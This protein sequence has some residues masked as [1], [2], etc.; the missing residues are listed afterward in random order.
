M[1]LYLHIQVY[2]INMSLSTKYNTS[3]TRVVWVVQ[4]YKYKI[5][6]IYIRN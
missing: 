6:Y 5:P 3:N 4:Y 2:I 1:L